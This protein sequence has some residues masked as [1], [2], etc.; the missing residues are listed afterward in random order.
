MQ[1]TC[2]VS[3]FAKNDLICI[4]VVET[5]SSELRMV[6]VIVCIVVTIINI[7]NLHHYY[8]NNIILRG[9]SRVRVQGMCTYLSETTCGFLIQL[10]FCKQQKR[11]FYWCWSRARDEVEAFFLVFSIKIK[12]FTSSVTSLLHHFL[13]VHPLQ[14][15]FPDPPVILVKY[16]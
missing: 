8:Y 15:K 2:H 16:C 3:N 7:L 9:R 5:L 1:L 14:K 6:A 4:K 12:L 13:V 11:V 10:V